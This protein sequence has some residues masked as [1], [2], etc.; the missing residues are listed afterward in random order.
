MRKRKMRVEQRRPSISSSRHPPHPH[1]ADIRQN[2]RGSPG[3]H[4]A[5]Q[6]RKIKGEKKIHLIPNFISG[7]RYY[8]FC[9]FLSAHIAA[10]PPRFSS[11]SASCL[12]PLGSGSYQLVM[13]PGGSGPRPW[14]QT[15]RLA[16]WLA[17]WPHISSQ[18][19]L[20]LF[21]SH[22]PPLPAPASPPPPLLLRLLCHTQKNAAWEQKEKLNTK[23]KQHEHI[24]EHL[25]K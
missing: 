17:G 18:D 20:F 9:S 1:H 10:P 22:P 4:H 14:T 25:H 6:Q 15:D 13:G 2:H 7:P 21:P 16:G 11:L 12:S 19:S 5:L 24:S 23:L 3:Y 8:P